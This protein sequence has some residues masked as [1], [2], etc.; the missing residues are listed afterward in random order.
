MVFN[1]NTV[2]GRV[3]NHLAFYQPERA[4]HRFVDH[5]SALNETI[6]QGRIV[7][8]GI[9]IDDVLVNDFG[10]QSFQTIQTRINIMYLPYYEYLGRNWTGAILHIPELGIREFR[11][12]AETIRSYDFTIDETAH[13]RIEAETD[14]YINKNI[15]RRM[16]VE[17]WKQPGLTGFGI[18]LELNN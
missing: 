11:S 7:K 18:H 2:I 5:P 14:H 9:L 8:M 17:A 15:Y 16:I 1:N 6:L 13:D 12:I 3:F 10:N 4:I